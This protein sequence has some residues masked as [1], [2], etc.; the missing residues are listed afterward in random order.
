MRIAISLLIAFFCASFTQ[1]QKVEIDGAINGF[2]GKTIKVGVFSDY[3]TNTKKELCRQTIE[4][5][6]FQFSIDLSSTSQVYMQIEDKKTSFFAEAGKSYTI[7]L[8]YDAAA[9]Q[10]RAY[11]KS[12][13]ISI[14]NE[15][16]NGLNAKIKQ[17]NQEYQEFFSKNYRS[18]VIGAAK[19]EI[20]LF[21][22][23]TQGNP[24]YLSPEFLKHYV[25]YALANLKDINKES[26]S[27]LATEYLL[28]QKVLINHK[29]Y[30]NFFQQLYQKDFEMLML[31]KEGVPIK[32][33]IMIDKDLPKTLDL[34]A[35]E[36]GFNSKE[37]TELYL[38]NGLYDTYHASVIEVESNK[39]FLRKLSKE[40][41]TANNQQLANNILKAVSLYQK[42]SAAPYFALKDS[43]GNL[44]K[45]NDYKGKL[46]YLNFWAKWS[47]PSL[48]E[49]KLMKKLQE[50]YGQQVHF[51]SINLDEEPSINKSEKERNGYAWDL[52]YGGADYELR[53][54]YEVKTVPLYYLI[55]AEGKMEQIFAPNPV[56]MDKIFYNRF[57]KTK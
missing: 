17:F 33:A 30:M 26:K 19:E 2:D 51:V 23:K 57:Q 1:A 52:L 48:R 20:N 16:A 24:N 11:D 13:D 54:K 36:K 14:T 37:L 55:D 49:M 46:L 44:K 50:E 21:I 56:Q 39:A 27:K 40:A 42:G 22:Q 29:E 35:T 32:K 15:G 18:F 4:K 53:E 5:G 10:G 12:L 25:R 45:L 43:E 3:L 47:I 34:I 41:S 38:L 6:S 7:K 28:G 31:K 9:N 8:S